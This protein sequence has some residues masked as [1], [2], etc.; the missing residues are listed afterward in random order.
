MT[1][2]VQKEKDIEKDDIIC[3]ESLFSSRKYLCVPHFYYVA[4]FPDSFVP[5]F[6]FPLCIYVTKIFDSVSCIC[7]SLSFLTGNINKKERLGVRF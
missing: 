4:L 6:V 7:M 5:S 2:Y 3:G 1:F